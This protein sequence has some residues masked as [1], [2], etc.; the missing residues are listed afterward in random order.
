[1]K[2]VVPSMPS[3]DGKEPFWWAAHV[4]SL[5]Q[6]KKTGTALRV[7]NRLLDM[8]I[9]RRYVLLYKVRLLQK[10]GRLKEAIAWV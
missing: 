7:L 3:A 4:N 6:Q 2:D 1:M 5:I 10:L 9:D 8:N